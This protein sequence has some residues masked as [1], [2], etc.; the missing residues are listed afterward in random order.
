[1]AGVAPP[2]CPGTTTRIA[3]ARA[4]PP[5]DSPRCQP[6]S[7]DVAASRS[8]AAKG[9]TDARFSTGTPLCSLA[10]R[11]KPEPSTAVGRIGRVRR[12]LPL[13]GS[14]LVD[15]LVA[16]GGVLGGVAGVGRGGLSPPRQRR[17]GGG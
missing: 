17:R 10:R 7:A 5:A 6:A 8:R 9:A 1:M 11:R 4:V 2:V 15:S 14:Y 13:S 3:C 16:A 12:T